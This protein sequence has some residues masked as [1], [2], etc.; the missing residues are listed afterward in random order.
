MRW[1]FAALV[2]GLAAC[3]GEVSAPGDGEQAAA[4]GYT[5]EIRA[6][7]AQQTYLIT[8][9]D[10]RI[11]GARAA[12]GAS[13]LMDA[14]RAQALAADPP[15]QSDEAPEVL[16]LRVPGFDLSIGANEENAEGD[17]GRVRLSLGGE[18]GQRV[19]VNANEGGP[20]DADDNAFVRITGADEQSVRD[21][22]AEQDELSPSVQAQMLAELG[23]GE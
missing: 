10:G 13:A 21:F 3:G 23:L 9:P 8:A 4:G 1:A 17:N 5:I 2:F 7:D 22:I 11:V 15:P 20:G 18:N 6:N 12:E 19:E 16:S 14:T